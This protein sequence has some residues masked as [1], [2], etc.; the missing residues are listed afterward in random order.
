[1]SE[2]GIIEAIAKRYGILPFYAELLEA[3]RNPYQR[4][5]LLSALDDDYDI[6]RIIVKYLYEVLPDILKK[7]IDAL[8]VSIVNAI[9]GTHAK[10]PK[11]I[12]S[13]FRQSA[14]K[15]QAG[16][17]SIIATYRQKD[18]TTVNILSNFDT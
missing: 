6:E 11:F 16:N 3:V 10:K 8:G 14:N 18:G 1:M 4:A 13:I 5:F 9:I 2:W 17:K 15:A 12:K 7:L